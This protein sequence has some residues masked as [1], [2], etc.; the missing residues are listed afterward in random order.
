MTFQTTHLK[1]N[2]T[3]KDRGRL[4]VSPAQLAAEWVDLKNTG[5]NAVN[6]TGLILKHVAYAPG[7]AQGH[8]EPVLTFTQGVLNPGQV[9]RVHAGQTRNHEVIRPEDRVGA[10][11]HLFSGKDEYVWNN[12]RGDIS[13]LW[14]PGAAAPYDSAGY[15]PPAPDGVILVR[16]GNALV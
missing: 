10:N 6:L 1:P 9:V 15:A 13:S 16:S 5:T 4:G 8:W 14:A 11:F 7:A 3:G 12:D 2:P